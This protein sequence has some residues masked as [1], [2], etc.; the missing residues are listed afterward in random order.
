MG[1]VLPVVNALHDF[2]DGLSLEVSLKDGAVE[3]QVQPL[4]LVPHLGV[5]VLEVDDAVLGNREVDSVVRI[6]LQGPGR[7]IFFML[8]FLIHS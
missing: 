8:E 7:L 2:L 1:L 3:D 5:L 6:H 4:A